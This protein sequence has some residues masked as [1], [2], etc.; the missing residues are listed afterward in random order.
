MPEPKVYIILIN[1]NGH[2]NTAETIESLSKQSYKNFQVIVVDN[3][4]PQSLHI[5]KEWCLGKQVIEFTPPDEI[6]KFSFP[7]CPKPLSWAD[8]EV[9]EAEKGGN[10]EKEKVAQMQADAAFRFPFIFIQARSD[11]GFAGGNNVGSHYALSKGDAD[12]VWLLNN[13]TTLDFDALK[14][15]IEKA[16][17][18]KSGS[19]KVGI[20]GSKLLWYR[21]PDK[22]NAIGGMFNKWTTWSYHL[23][24]RETDNGQYN[25]DDVKFDYV[26]G[27]SLF[28][29][30]AFLEDVGFMNEMYYA[31]FEEM[32][33]AVR[34]ARRG[35]KHGYAYKS[36]IY[37]KQGV[38]TGKEIK[39]KRRPQ[40]F[41]C[42]KYRGWM[43][44]YQLYYPYLIFAPV[45]RLIGKALKN[46]TEGNSKESILILKILLGKRTCHRDTN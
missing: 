6:K 28:L 17:E 26:Y 35:W 32:D 27:A 33:W 3:N 8:Y 29:Y 45:F 14:M 13:D 1:F 40:F 37:H 23:G 18:Y 39:S 24:L 19:E 41:M 21:W 15:L 25:R 22:I 10:I 43:L 4:T 20:I 12:Y 9:E 31:Y 44:F 11:I 46:L 2:A 5:I 36:V 34:G 38:T 16:G 7:Y 30:K 42:C